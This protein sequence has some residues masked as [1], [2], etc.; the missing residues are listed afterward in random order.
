MA[1]VERRLQPAQLG[2][3]TF[4]Q[5]HNDPTV[6]FDET[7][8]PIDVWRGIT[9]TDRTGQRRYSRAEIDAL[10][11]AGFDVTIVEFTSEWRQ[12]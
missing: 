9:P 10:A 3:R 11:A 2:Y 8:A 1:A 5:S 4:V 6:Y 7:D 12:L